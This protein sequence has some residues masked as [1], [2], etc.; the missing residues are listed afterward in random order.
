VSRYSL[1]A[2]MVKSKEVQKSN[3]NEA[4]G[5]DRTQ[6]ESIPTDY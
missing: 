4:G 5:D 6:E 1:E 2:R 3:S